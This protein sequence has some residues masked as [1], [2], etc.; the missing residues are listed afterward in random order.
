ME[1]ADRLTTRVA[2][3]SLAPP[4]LGLALAPAFLSLWLGDYAALTLATMVALCLGFSTNMLTGIQASVAEAIGRPG[5]ST[6]A[7]V[8]TAAL[9]VTLGVVL[10]VTV[11]PTGLVFGT[12]AA[13]V[14]GSAYNIALVQPAVGSTQKRYYRLI[15]GPPVLGL[16]AALLS[17]LSTAWLPTDDRPDAALAVAI[18][19]AVFFAFYLVTTV[20]RG[21][22]PRHYLTRPFT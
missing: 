1:L 9:S 11:G 13:I 10:L 14:I 2:T 3:L 8:V 22:L 7:A 5:L 4:L 16:A 18:G 21:Y 15:A 20:W 12:A 19:T 6:K 17:F